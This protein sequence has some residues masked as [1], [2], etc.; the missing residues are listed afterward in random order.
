MSVKPGDFKGKR[1][2]EAAGAAG[3]GSGRVDARRDGGV[4]DR[5]DALASSGMRACGPASGEGF[6]YSGPSSPASGIVPSA[7]G[8]VVGSPQPAAGPS[9][10]TRPIE[11]AGV[12]R[13]AQSDW[14]R[15]AHMP[16]PAPQAG[17]PAQNG[18]AGSGAAV[19][20]RDGTPYASGTGAPQPSGPAHLGQPAANAAQTSHAAPDPLARRI[21]EQQAVPYGAG[22]AQAPEGTAYD[23]YDP[24]ETWGVYDPQGLDGREGQGSDAPGAEPAPGAYPGLGTLA[25]GILSSADRAMDSFASRDDQARS[26]FDS[27]GPESGEFNAIEANEAEFSRRNASDSRWEGAGARGRRSSRDMAAGSMSGAAAGVLARRP[28]L[29]GFSYSDAGTG[30]RAAA[31]DGEA[32]DAILGEFMG[33]SERSRR[34]KGSGGKKDSRA[35]RAARRAGELAETVLTGGDSDGSASGDMIVSARSARRAWSAS[36]KADHGRIRS[37]GAAGLAAIERADD[38]YVAEGVA[39]VHM[40]AHRVKQGYRGARAAKRGAVKAGGKAAEGARFAQ[41]RAKRM[42]MSIA[43]AAKG[44][45]V[46]SAMSAGQAAAARAR[47]AASAVASSIGN[48]LGALAS[49][50]GAPMAIALPVILVVLII[51]GAAAGDQESST[52]GLTEREQAFYDYFSDKGYTDV[53]IAAIAGNIQQESQ[54][55]PS[56]GS[57]RTHFGLCQWGGRRLG[58]LQGLCRGRGKPTDDFDTQVE[59][60]WAEMT[61]SVN[62]TMQWSEATYRTFR[63]KGKQSDL[64]GC[65]HLFFRYYERANDDT[66]PKRLEHAQDFLSRI[67]G[68]SVDSISDANLKSIVSFCYSSVGTAGYQN[69][70]YTGSYPD[71]SSVRSITCTAYTA[72][73]YAQAGVAI[74]GTSGVTKPNGRAGTPSVQK[75]AVVAAGDWKTDISALE[76]G[77][78]VFFRSNT[79]NSD[80]EGIGHVAIYVGGGK[81]AH[82]YT[83]RGTN[84]GI[85]SINMGGIGTFIGGGC[86]FKPS[87]E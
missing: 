32:R 25:D 36:R 46:V 29:A 42:S 56:A 50:L 73:A 72:W 1:D 62:R 85:T 49:A 35:R 26:S 82:S 16:G 40:G 15:P 3:I 21:H 84:P 8:G 51:A 30:G 48:G 65:V 71:W 58:E 69:S 20:T 86:P 6:T 31:S 41:E 22:G 63:A 27:K 55:S 79:G 87:G 38:N 74:P 19:P 44:G 45:R 53:E 81:I 11:T 68:A 64:K 33:A 83:R 70:G 14:G 18:Y 17:G 77:D 47:A 24:F 13:L 60:I 23:P 12:P 59:F 67:Y 9:A 43:R 57:T 34:G 52:T 39:S 75:A 76:P 7:G 4:T 37:L 10:P 80:P 78:L 5:F 54:F 61:G 66:E 2:R 28:E